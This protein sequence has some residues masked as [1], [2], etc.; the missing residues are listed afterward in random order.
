MIHIAKPFTV[1]SSKKRFR[2]IA[3]LHCSTTAIT[4]TLILLHGAFF[5][6]TFIR[7]A[8]LIEPVPSN[9]QTMISVLCFGIA[10]LQTLHIIRHLVFELESQCKSLDSNALV[11]KVWMLRSLWSQVIRDSVWVVAKRSLFIQSYKVCITE[12]DHSV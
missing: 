10:C 9:F 12:T 5:K 11:Y 2:F 7:L 4:C 1:G 6:K 8:S 3:V